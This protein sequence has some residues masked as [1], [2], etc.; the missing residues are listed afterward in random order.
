[1]IQ[2]PVSDGT[3][4]TLR[5]GCYLPG[6]LP[7]M[8]RNALL[9][10][11]SMRGLG[12]LVSPRSQALGPGDLPGNWPS[13]LEA[14]AAATTKADGPMTC[15]MAAACPSASCWPCYAVA[16]VAWN[17]MTSGLP[18]SGAGTACEPSLM[19]LSL[20]ASGPAGVLSAAVAFPSLGMRVHYPGF[21][22]RMRRRVLYVLH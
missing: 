11:V 22:Q 7:C 12:P 4:R 8:E 16:M 3:L 10:G 14:V 18:P 5:W 2:F 17:S 9:L 15:V 19:T 21:G 6:V 1:M 13:P 20:S